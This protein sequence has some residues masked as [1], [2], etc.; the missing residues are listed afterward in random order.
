LNNSILRVPLLGGLL[1]SALCLLG[2]GVVPAKA[3]EL[4][5]P[6]ATKSVRNFSRVVGWPQGKTP[7]APPG[8]TVSKFAGDLQSPRNLYVAP[9]G[10]IFVSEANTEK[11]LVDRFEYHVVGA[12]KAQCITGS[13]KRITLLRDANG[14]GIPEVRTVFLKDL[15]QPFGLLVLNGY[16]YVANQ[17]AVWRY[18]YK[19]GQLEM[20]AKGEKLI[21]LPV[22]G[23]NNHWTRNL[24]ASHD[25]KH[26]YVTVGSGSN[27][28]E[29]GLANEIRRANI[30][31]IDPD[32]HNE[33][34]YASGLRN[35]VGM[36]WGPGTDTLWTAVNERDE[37]GDELVPDYLTS[38]Q[39]GGFYGWPYSYF[40]KHV[41]DRVKEQRP[42]LVARAIVPD[43]QLGSHTASLGLAFYE[44][45]AFPA[46]YRGGAFIGQHGSWNRSTLSGYEV[47]YVPFAKGKPS[48]PMETFLGGFIV[49]PGKNDVYGR[50]VGV[51]VAPDGALL[52]ADD[53]GNTVWRVAA[54]ENKQSTP[55][56]P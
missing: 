12:D 14:D 40:G 35:P 22:G 17:D 33:K 8:F 15:N 38:V 19:D 21:D 55:S 42:D 49:T 20:K 48:G 5:P 56:A 13:A 28:G 39:R 26:L 51:A 1:A 25:G 31:E 41:D 23:Y 43:L 52:V 3:P 53:A 24:L 50:P 16:F 4:P 44:S 34:I 37:L 2:A 11:G 10:D 46:K 47:V 45:K 30:L 54:T 29:H 7:V 27:A 9:N 18:P 36:A 32:G 6:H